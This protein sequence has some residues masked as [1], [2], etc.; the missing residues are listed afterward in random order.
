[1]FKNGTFSNVLEQILT[2]AS[3][4]TNRERL[5]YMR[6]MGITDPEIEALEDRE[7]SD[8]DNKKTNE[9][10][11]VF[12]AM[13]QSTLPDADV[14]TIPFDK[15]SILQNTDENYFF[16]TETM[17]SIAAKLTVR[18]MADLFCFVDYVQNAILKNDDLI[19]MVHMPSLRHMLGR[20]LTPVLIEAQR[21]GS[22]ILSM[23]DVYDVDGAD[24]LKQ[25]NAGTKY[26]D[27]EAI[28]S[29]DAMV[30]L[31]DTPAYTILLPA[32]ADTLLPDPS[33][34]TVK[35]LAN[36]MV[37]LNAFVLL[38][39]NF[40]VSFSQVNKCIAFA[41]PAKIYAKMVSTAGSVTVN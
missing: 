14:T 34:L 26:T 27:N 23:F 39:K 12:L 18:Q 13:Q 20:Q 35:P 15:E 17:R 16:S 41:D 25:A 7:Q 4:S 33:G 9:L 38:T 31:F 1:M 40:I 8:L 32:F 6:E 5:V 36:G 37:R 30:K 2:G 19:A 29:N 3:E 24:I 10:L 22:L 11:N 21:S 28:T